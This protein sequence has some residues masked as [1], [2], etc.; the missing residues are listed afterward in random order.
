MASNG[1]VP[2]RTA[3]WLG[4]VFL[5]VAGGAVAT[6]ASTP[7]ASSGLTV[8]ISVIVIVAL[9]LTIRYLRAGLQ[10]N[11]VG[12]VSRGDFWTRELRWTDVAN[13]EVRRFT[14]GA[15][16]RDGRWLPLHVAQRTPP[17]RDELVV[18]L[19]SGLLNRA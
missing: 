11:S 3:R 2:N 6:L 9:V 16:L 15:R 12:F 18:A 5:M 4:V 19:R 1:W 10:L 8:M 7:D 13:I 17:E 14:V